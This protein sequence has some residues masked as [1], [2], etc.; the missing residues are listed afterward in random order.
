V[1]FERIAAVVSFLLA[2]TGG[3]WVFVFVSSWNVVGADRIWMWALLLGALA[4]GIVFGMLYLVVRPWS[5]AFR[6]LET[7]AVLASV[8][9]R[10]F[11]WETTTL[12]FADKEYAERFALV[13]QAEQVRDGP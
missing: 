3:I 5:T 4:M 10:D 1:R 12:D 8:R 2:W 13:N 11:D 6:S 7:K 9:I